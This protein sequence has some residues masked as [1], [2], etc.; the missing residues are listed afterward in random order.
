MAD[1]LLFS[2]GTETFYFEFHQGHIKRGGGICSPDLIHQGHMPLMPNT[3]H[4][5]DNY[6]MIKFLFLVNFPFF[7]TFSRFATF[8]LSIRVVFGVIFSFLIPIFS[9]FKQI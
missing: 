6:C 5:S 2:S 7:D 3:G 1:S 8:F 9:L 4:A